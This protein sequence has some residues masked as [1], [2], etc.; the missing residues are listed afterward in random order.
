LGHA[1]R[2]GHGGHGLHD[3][4]TELGTALDAFATD[5]GA[6]LD[7]VTLLTLSEFGRRIEENGSGG[8]DHGYGQTVFLLGGGVKGGQVHG[9]WPGLAPEDLIDGDLDKTTDYRTILAEV[10]E[11]R[12]EAGSA[13]GIFPGMPTSR[14]DV[15]NVR[16]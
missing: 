7:D 12:C 14:P 10:L 8:T 15:V 6:K 4:L 5:L 13:S 11:K 9:V 1:R 2:H 3:H 16:L